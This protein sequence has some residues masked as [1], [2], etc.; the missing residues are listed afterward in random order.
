MPKE[1]HLSGAVL[2]PFESGALFGA[3]LYLALCL[4]T[5]LHKFS[6]AMSKES[7]ISLTILGSLTKCKERFLGQNEQNYKINFFQ[8]FH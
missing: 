8:I 1:L 5:N 6:M 3:I 7:L 4:L 2:E